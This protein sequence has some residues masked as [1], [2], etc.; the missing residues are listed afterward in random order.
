MASK[1]A[2]RFPTPSMRCSARATGVQSGFSGKHDAVFYNLRQHGV[3]LVS[4]ELAGGVVAGVEVLSEKG[5]ICRLLNPWPGE[6]LQLEHPDGSAQ[7]LV[8][9]V[10]AFPTVQGSSYRIRRVS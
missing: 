2:V 4:A 7:A 3:F 9:E 1:P 6:I 5:R 10:V 8:G